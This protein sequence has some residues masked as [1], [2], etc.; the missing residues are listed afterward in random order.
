MKLKLLIAFFSIA[1]SLSALR[2]TLTL[3][4]NL[5]SLIELT[6]SIWQARPANQ[7]NKPIIGI[8]TDISD[9]KISVNN[10]YVRAII[11]AGGIPYI[12]PSSNDPLLVG[13]II[14]NLDGIVFTGGK[15]V[16]PMLYNEQPHQNLEAVSPERDI[17]DL[18]WIHFAL[19]QDLTIPVICRGAL[20]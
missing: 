2:A 8:S 13:T 15:D 16:H 5:N 17:S 11:R 4:N 12:L 19:Q 14:E 9:G 1:T 20:F 10:T 3:D 6:D 18:P 7:A